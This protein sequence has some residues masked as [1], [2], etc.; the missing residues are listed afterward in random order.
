M[1]KTTK[2]GFY[3]VKVGRV[4]GVY[5]TWDECKAQVNGFQGGKHKK[6]PTLGEAQAFVNG[7]APT[8]TASSSST[9]TS[10]GKGKGRAMEGDEPAAKR[11]KT[12]K[13]KDPVFGTQESKYPARR[14]VYSDG[15][16]KGNGKKGAVAGSG[17]FWSHEEGANNLAERLPGVLQTNNRAE[18]YAV[19]RILETDPHPEEPLLI[20]TDSK[21]TIEVFTSYIPGWRARG[22]R[23]SSGTTPLNSDLIRYI[24]SLLALRTVHASK[25]SSSSS[26]SDSCMANV[27]FKWIKG[28]AGQ[29]GNEMADKLANQ[30]AA[31]PEAVDR[32]FDQLAKDNEKKLKESKNVKIHSIDEVTWDVETADLLT[33]EELREMERTQE[34]E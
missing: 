9:S 4:P 15:S 24:L 8:P 18:M 17:V 21:Y 27:K 25:P 22:W 29:D 6:F 11:Q 7:S 2:P 23:T 20:C 13:S 5:K 30:G 32:D 3:A 16:S 14:I 26:S 28:H 19:A 31:L 12:S 34:F 1:A 10:N 33:E